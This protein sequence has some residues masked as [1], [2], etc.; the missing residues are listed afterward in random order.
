[1]KK[2]FVKGGRQSNYL[3][4]IL[5]CLVWFIDYRKINI[6]HDKKDKEI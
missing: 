6:Y 5:G 3:G 4:W 1:M 2:S